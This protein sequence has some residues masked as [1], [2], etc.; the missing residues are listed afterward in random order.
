MPC[1]ALYTFLKDEVVVG[2]EDEVVEISEVVVTEDEVVVGTRDEV[3]ELLEVVVTEDEVVVVSE[4][5]LVVGT[6]DE[7]VVGTGD[8]VVVG[9]GDEVVVGTRDEVVGVSEVVVTRDEVVV[10]TG[11]E[12][13]GVSE[14][15]A[16]NN[17]KSVPESILRKEGV[18]PFSLFKKSTISFKVSEEKGAVVSGEERDVPT[19]QFPPDFVITSS[20]PYI[21]FGRNAAAA[22]IVPTPNNAKIPNPIPVSFGCL[23]KNLQEVVSV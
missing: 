16:T 22:A 4:D 20:S 2:T 8:E 13:V 18:V 11:D 7:V 14:D 5:K 12:V 3:V 15:E 23:E 21:E 1:P 17:A 10:G 19:G 9:T 6:R